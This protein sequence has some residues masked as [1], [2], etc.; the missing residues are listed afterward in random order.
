MPAAEEVSGV[1]ASFRQKNR[2][3]LYIASRAQTCIGVR[4]VCDKS[5]SGFRK[6]T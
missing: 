4:Q 5:D 6:T 2:T 3:S 1:A